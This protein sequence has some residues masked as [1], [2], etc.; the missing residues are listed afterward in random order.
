MC[1]L[2]QCFPS[3][4]F[5]SLVSAKLPAAL[6]RVSYIYQLMRVHSKHSNSRG[7]P[8]FT[9]SRFVSVNSLSFCTPNFLKLLI[10]DSRNPGTE[11]QLRILITIR[12][13][14]CGVLSITHYKT[15]SRIVRLALNSSQISFELFLKSPSSSFQ[16]RRHGPQSSRRV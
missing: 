12:S 2:S 15:S 11:T 13:R 14:L 5:V 1:P 6:A 4:V 7:Q 9:W 3:S 10:S 8:G 16:R